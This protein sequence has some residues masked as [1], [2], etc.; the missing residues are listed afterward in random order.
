MRSIRAVA[1]CPKEILPHFEYIKIGPYIKDKGLLNSAPT[2][3]Q[4]YLIKRG[5]PDRFLAEDIT[6]LLQKKEI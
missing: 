3:Q 4:L 5:F 2:N 1:Y 6:A